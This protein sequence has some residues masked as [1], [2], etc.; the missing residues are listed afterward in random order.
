MLFPPSSFH[1]VSAPLFYAAL[2]LAVLG[3][4]LLFDRMSEPVGAYSVN[5]VEMALNLQEQRDRELLASV[6]APR[7]GRRPS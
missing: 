3:F 5:A 2:L 4:G 1:G 6:P 7:S